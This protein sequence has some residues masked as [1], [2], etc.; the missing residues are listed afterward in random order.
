MSKVST[1]NKTRNRKLELQRQRQLIW[2]AQMFETANKG[3]IESVYD[4]M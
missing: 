1:V 4:F 2:I 3:E